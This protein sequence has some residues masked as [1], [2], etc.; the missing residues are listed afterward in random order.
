[1][2]SASAYHFSSFFAAVKGYLPVTLTP[3]IGWTEIEV[4]AGLIAACLPLLGT[5]LTALLP[6]HTRP[7]ATDGGDEAETAAVVMVLSTEG[8]VRG[9]GGLDLDLDLD[10]D[11]DGEDGSWRSPT[12]RAA[13]KF[14]AGDSRRTSR[15]ASLWSN[16][17]GGNGGN[18]GGNKRGT[19]EHLSNLDAWDWE[20]AVDSLTR[21]DELS[22]CQH[23]ASAARVEDVEVPE[24]GISVTTDFRRWSVKEL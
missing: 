23:E 18:G 9:G 1:M 13:N 17:V 7:A 22:M 2:T 12:A 24:H 19:Q 14:S 8:G 21:A 15:A 4:A 11:V 3:A 20:R 5:I 16:T 6:S 10:L